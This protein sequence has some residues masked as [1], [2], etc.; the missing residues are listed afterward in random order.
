MN[1]SLFHKKDQDAERR[2]A[3]SKV[4][5]LLIRLAKETEHIPMITN[6]S[7]DEKIDTLIT[8]ST[9]ISHERADGLISQ[10]KIPP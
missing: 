9:N 1:V 8:I 6:N 3:L 4:Y 10:E 2:R 5:S 7:N